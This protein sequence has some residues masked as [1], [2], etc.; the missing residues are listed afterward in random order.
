M[1]RRCTTVDEVLAAGQLPSDRLAAGL[2]IEVLWEGRA[3]IHEQRRA[4]RLLDQWM[5]CE[6]QERRPRRAS[7][8]LL[9]L[10]ET[11]IA[12]HGTPASA[13]KAMA[14]EDKPGASVEQLGR[15]AASIERQHD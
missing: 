11:A 1:S 8:L 10:V 3:N 5:P 6:L 14:T 2:L 7:E 12:M 9:E 13:Y 15:R 4:A